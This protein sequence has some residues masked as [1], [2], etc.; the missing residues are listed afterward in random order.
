MS[1][2]EVRLHYGLQIGRRILAQVQQFGFQGN[3]DFSAVTRP[4]GIGKSVE[5]ALLPGIEPAADGLRMHITQGG[6]LFKGKA[7]G[8]KQDGLCPLPQPMNRAVPMHLF[9]GSPLGI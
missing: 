2:F 7:F 4:G 9:Q 1:F 6:Q 8:G 5:A 3:V